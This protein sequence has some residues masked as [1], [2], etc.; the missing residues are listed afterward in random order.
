MPISAISP[1]GAWTSTAATSNG[2]FARADARSAAEASCTDLA[3]AE[4]LVAA[5]EGAV[6][7]MNADHA[8][9]LALYATRL[10]RRAR[11]RAG[12][13]PA[14]TPKGIDLAAGDAR[15]APRLS[16]SASRDA[17]EL[18]SVLVAMAAAARGTAREPIA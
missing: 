12:A 10:A 8:E 6:A 7:H 14:S 5:E 1:S 17:G 4:A 9:A 16:P 11:R 13:R 18:R 2:G 3:G 15:R